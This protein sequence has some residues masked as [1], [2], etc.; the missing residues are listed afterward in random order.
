MDDDSGGEE[1]TAGR[2]VDGTTDVVALV[3]ATGGA[4]TTRLTLETGALLA[5][6]GRR[7]AAFDAAFGT[8]GMVDHV[9][10]RVDADVV[11]LVTDDDVSPAEAMVELTTAGKGSVHLAP[12]RAPFADLARAKT[13]AAARS[14]ASTLREAADR[15]DYVL[16]DTPPV[17]TNQAVAA[18]TAADRVGAVA[19][20]TERG[21]DAVQ[22]VRARTDDVGTG[23]DVTVGNQAPPGAAIADDFDAVVPESDRSGPRAV[24]TA[25]VGD[26]AFTEGVA[27]IAELLVGVDIG[28]TFE[29]GGYLERL[30]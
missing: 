18:V 26:G 8:Q 17:A 3:G 28:V 16:V 22:R 21:L 19:P 9:E 1:G 12:A 5:R 25:D 23:V 29:T 13:E 20:A 27:S 14:L 24:P 4:G 30:P 15:F 6:E 7:V 2:V 11:D 10:G